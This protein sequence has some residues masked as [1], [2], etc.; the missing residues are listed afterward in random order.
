MKQANITNKRKEQILRN[1]K[2]NYDKK[3][4][5]LY[6]YNDKLNVYSNIIIGDFHIEFTKDKKIAGIEVLK[7][8]EILE[9]YQI[10][11]SVLENI[12]EATLK[13]VSR[14]ESLII[15][16]VLKGLKEEKSAAITMN[17]LDSSIIKA[18]VSV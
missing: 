17:S 16:I 11:K 15:F 10:G 14:N 2:F 4:D 6:I 1:L 18:L 5:L 9:E 3:N 7:A 13:V 12:Q 8:S